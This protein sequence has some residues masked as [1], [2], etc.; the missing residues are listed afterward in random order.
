MLLFVCFIFILLDFQ[1]NLSAK[2]MTQMQR[3]HLEYSLKLKLEPIAFLVRLEKMVDVDIVMKKRKY[4][5]G[6]AKH[7]ADKARSKKSEPQFDFQPL[8]STEGEAGDE[9][10]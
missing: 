6:E 8:L 7:Q 9:E 2:T 1:N 4:S 3:T 10:R 5:P